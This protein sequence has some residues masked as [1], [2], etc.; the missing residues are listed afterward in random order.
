MVEKQPAVVHLWIDPKL[1]V[2]ELQQQLATRLHFDFD[3]IKRLMGREAPGTPSEAGVI[4]GLP[5][6][7]VGEHMVAE[8]DGNDFDYSPKGPTPG[9]LVGDTWQW[10]W[11]VTPKRASN[12]G[13]FLLTIKAW[14]DDPRHR[15]VF[16][17]VNEPVIVE[18]V[19]PTPQGRIQRWTEWLKT[20]ED[21]YKALAAVVAILLP[22]LIAFRKRLRELLR[23]RR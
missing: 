7:M 14:N 6:V 22:L 18:A 16:P 12:G 17:S 3:K 10:Q 5:Q 11:Q 13:H 23:S 9:L 15:V 2:D 19:P 4:Q 20:L 21:F 1:P 8:L